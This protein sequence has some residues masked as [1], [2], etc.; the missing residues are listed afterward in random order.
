MK[1]GM[2]VEG[3][4]RFEG[5]SIDVMI[6]GDR[7]RGGCGCGG[8][9]DRALTGGS[10]GLHEILREALFSTNCIVLFGPEEKGKGETAW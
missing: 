6:E 2:K 7:E 10:L 8:M 1:E 3:E 9:N 5:A 4:R